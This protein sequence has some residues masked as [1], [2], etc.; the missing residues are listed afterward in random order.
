MKCFK[1]TIDISCICI[2]IVFG[3]SLIFLNG[4]DPW[5]TK[6]YIFPFNY[7]LQEQGDWGGG[8]VS[9]Q[10]LYIVMLTSRSGGLLGF[11]AMLPEI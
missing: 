8:W 5:I 9:S 11:R 4:P 1:M 10:G 7:L 3:G 6:V 2:T